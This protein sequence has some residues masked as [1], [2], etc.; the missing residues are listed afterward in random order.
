MHEYGYPKKENANMAKNQ[1]TNNREE[2]S[3]FVLFTIK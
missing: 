2:S 3:F 1:I